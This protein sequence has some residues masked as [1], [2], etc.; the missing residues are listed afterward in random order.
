MEG[1]VVF[2]HQS[3]T[4]LV[5]NMICL[6]QGGLHSLSASSS[7]LKAISFTNSREYCS[8]YDKNSYCMVGFATCRIVALMWINA[9]GYARAL[10]HNCATILHVA[11]LPCND[12]IIVT[13]HHFGLNLFMCYV[14]Q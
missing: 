3:S 13:L 14:A 4:F 1:A 2:H 6:C 8:Q 9:L 10:I 5:G 7:I 11:P 12:Y